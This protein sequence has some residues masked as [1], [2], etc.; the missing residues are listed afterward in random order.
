MRIGLSDMA[1]YAYPGEERTVLVEFEQLYESDTFRSRMRKQQ[2]WRRASDGW[3]I[4][5]EAK[6]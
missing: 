3:K 4:V 1:I 2:Y 6:S 5:F